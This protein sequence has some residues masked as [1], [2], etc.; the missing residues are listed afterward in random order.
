[1]PRDE[2]DQL[3]REYEMIGE[4]DHEAPIR[5]P[6]TIV[7]FDVT[8]TERSSYEVSLYFLN[9]TFLTQSHAF[10]RYW[11]NRATMDLCPIVAYH[12]DSKYSSR[13]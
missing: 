6:V 10:K 8:L 7:G 4:Y 1:M 13:D 9:S 12:Q 11:N 2:L 5:P 3:Y